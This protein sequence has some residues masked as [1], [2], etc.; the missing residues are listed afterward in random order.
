MHRRAA[1]GF[2]TPVSQPGC[3]MMY[4]H[5]LSGRETYGSHNR[6]LPVKLF[7]KVSCVVQLHVQLFVEQR[8]PAVMTT[9]AA[10]GLSVWGRGDAYQILANR[11]GRAG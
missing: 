4:P 8:L 2:A 3:Y 9:W 11:A 7:I 6:S 5:N 1:E 10:R